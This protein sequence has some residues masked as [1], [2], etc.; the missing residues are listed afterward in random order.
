MTFLVSHSSTPDIGDE[1]PE[2]NE[3]FHEDVEYAQRK[4]TVFFFGWFKWSRLQWFY[5]QEAGIAPPRELNE[6]RYHDIK[7]SAICL[8]A[9]RELVQK[10]KKSLKE[11][12]PAKSHIV[13]VRFGECFESD[14]IY[15]GISTR[16]N[17]RKS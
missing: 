5:I 8:P 7:R 17:R 4:S 11:A 15:Y 10:L 12:C 9:Q 3:A 6:D 1:E 16:I 2:V 13:D 14:V